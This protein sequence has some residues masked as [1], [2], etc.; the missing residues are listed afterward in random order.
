VRCGPPRRRPGMLTTVRGSAPRSRRAP[1]GGPRCWRGPDH[2]PLSDLCS[3][4]VGWSRNQ[5]GEQAVR[6]ETE[7]PQQGG[8]DQHQLQHHRVGRRVSWGRPPGESQPIRPQLHP[9][10][11]PPGEWPCQEACEQRGPDQP[12]DPA[13]ASTRDGEVTGPAAIQRLDALQTAG[14]GSAGAD[15]TPRGLGPEPS[16]GPICSTIRNRAR[17]RLMSPRSPCKASG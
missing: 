6:I 4:A 1:Q 11:G 9:L 13:P 5:T 12:F 2:Q 3:L 10:E 15:H 14:A 17:C 8:I 7:H 16:R